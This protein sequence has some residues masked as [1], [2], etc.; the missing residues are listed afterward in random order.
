MEFP[1]LPAVAC[2]EPPN[3]LTTAL[4]ASSAQDP[5]AC[6]TRHLRKPARTYWSP[7]PSAMRLATYPRSKV[8]PQNVAGYFD[9]LQHRRGFVF[10]PRSPQDPPR[11]WLIHGAQFEPPP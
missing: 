3:Q 1:R 5:D 8:A 4:R 10:E 11:R 6:Q 9:R 2:S 7:K